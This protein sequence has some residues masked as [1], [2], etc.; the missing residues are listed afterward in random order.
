[1]TVLNM[2]VSGRMDSS[3][4]FKDWK[5]MLKKHNQSILS[6]FISSESRIFIVAEL[7]FFVEKPS[8]FLKIG[9]FRISKI[10]DFPKKREFQKFR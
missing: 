10:I 1:M 6:S 9:N 7:S 4:E 5:Q 2:K 3:G 8:T